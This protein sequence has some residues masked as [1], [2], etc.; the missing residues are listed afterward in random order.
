MTDYTKIGAQTSTVTGFDA[1]LRSFMLRIYKYMCLALIVTGVV[2]F[3]AGTSESFQHL[4]VTS[5]GGVLKP[6][7]IFYAVAFAP[8]VPWA[9]YFFNRGRMSYQSTHLVFWSYATLLGLSLSMIFEIYTGAS[10][11][12]V[13]LISAAMFGGMSLY[14]YSTKR[15]LTAMGSFLIMGMWGLVIAFLVNAF[16]HSAALDYALSVI[17]VGIFT[18]LVAYMN[19]QLKQ[20]YFQVAG[21]QQAEGKAAVFGAMTLYI[22]FMNLFMNLLR[23]LGNRR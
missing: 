8:M 16:M 23:L 5:Q 3:A 9:F 11:F 12:R 7:M 14:G 18:G 20:I 6:S 21:N 13:F 19:Q 22:T 1:G 10:I 4:M 2:A 17:G 15:D